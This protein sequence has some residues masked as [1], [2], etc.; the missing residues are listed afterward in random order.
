MRSVWLC[1][2]HNDAARKRIDAACAH[3]LDKSVDWWEQWFRVEGERQLKSIKE[4]CDVDLLGHVYGRAS[5][6][7]RTHA[8]GG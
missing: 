6:V 8:S 2:K 4:C 1:P 3:N 7:Q 5:T